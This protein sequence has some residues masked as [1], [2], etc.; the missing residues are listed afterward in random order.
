M[1]DNEHR[2][3]TLLMMLTNKK[4]SKLLVFI[5]EISLL[6]L[7][8]PIHRNNEPI[9]NVVRCELTKLI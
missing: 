8:D 4:R 7:F 1:F 9:R 5:R 6:V 3:L 2:A